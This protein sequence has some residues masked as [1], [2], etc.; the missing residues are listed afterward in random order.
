MAI[1]EITLD[2]DD[3]DTLSFLHDK[4][5]RVF[6][7]VNSDSAGLP[8]VW[9]SQNELSRTVKFSWAEQYA[10]YVKDGGT[11]VAGV[12]VSDVSA[13]PMELGEML[14]AL[15][16]GDVSVARAGESG[17]IT[18][19][20][21]SVRDWMCGM[22]QE[23]NGKMSPIC[24]F[25]LGGEGEKVI[26]KPFEKVLLVFETTSEIDTGTVVARALSASISI[27]LDG[28]NLERKVVFRKSTGWTTNTETWAT[29]N[30]DDLDLA[31]ALIVPG[32]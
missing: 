9:F 13:S 32:S 23:V 17:A 1:Y 22:G 12:D 18:V 6:K 2:L 14:V 10:G 15:A 21:N 20:N 27:E 7:S 16:D 25:D 8:V 28:S 11:P 24:A 26:M 4:S 30:D 31:S 29:I 3:G 19:K 5:L